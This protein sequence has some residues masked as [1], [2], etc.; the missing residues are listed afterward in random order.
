MISPERRAEIERVLE[1]AQARS[2]LRRRGV[3]WW[4][5]YESGCGMVVAQPDG[6]KITERDGKV[7]RISH[8]GVETVL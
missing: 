4:R 1:I 2:A 6:G 3:R 7:T 5:F 8:D